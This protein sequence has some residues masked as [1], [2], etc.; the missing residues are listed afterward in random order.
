MGD[1]CMKSEDIIDETQKVGVL[2]DWAYNHLMNVIK[3]QRA[4]A[5]KE[6]V[7]DVIQ[8]AYEHW[9]DWD[10]TLEESTEHWR[11]FEDGIRKKYG[12]KNDENEADS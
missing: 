2:S 6:A 7:K 10:G 3:E 1:K 4:K 8:M 9:K 11:V 5:A 12:I